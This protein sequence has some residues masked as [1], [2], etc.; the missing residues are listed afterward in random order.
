MKIMYSLESI[1]DRFDELSKHF[2]EE[3]IITPAPPNIMGPNWTDEI[4]VK[5]GY[6]QQEDGSWVKITNSKSLFDATKKQVLDMHQTKQEL[7]S[8]V[9]TLHKLTRELEYACRV[10][11]KAVV[12][13]NKQ[14]SND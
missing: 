13:I 12:N 7:Y 1:E 5:N 8:K 6:T 11:A 9:E 2:L 3:D 10:A 14:R 4:R